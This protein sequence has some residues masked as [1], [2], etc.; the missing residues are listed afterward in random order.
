MSFLAKFFA[1]KV[2]KDLL[3]KLFA[4]LAGWVK[5]DQWHRRKDAERKEEVRQEMKEIDDE[6]SQLDDT[7][8]A[9]RISRR[10]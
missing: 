3:S 8:L 1:R 10:D 7:S 2:I 9:D 6:V 4:Y 5:A